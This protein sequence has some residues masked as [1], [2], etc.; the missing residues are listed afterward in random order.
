MYDGIVL[1]DDLTPLLGALTA[2]GAV[3]TGYFDCCFAGGMLDVDR[4]GSTLGGPPSQ[5]RRKSMAGP[6]V[7]PNATYFFAGLQSEKTV[8]S[9]MAEEDKETDKT[10]YVYHGQ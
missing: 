4:T 7:G 8:D 9:I 1:D 2:K 10:N 5:T 6:A 3:L